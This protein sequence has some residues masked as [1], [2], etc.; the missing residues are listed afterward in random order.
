MTQDTKVKQCENCGTELFEPQTRFHR[1][2]VTCG[3]S[4]C[5]REARNADIQDR[6][7]ADEQLD[8]DLGWR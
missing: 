5:E 6:E 7:E 8:I 3:S 1:E 4:E 2:M